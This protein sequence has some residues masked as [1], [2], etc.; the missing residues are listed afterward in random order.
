MLRETRALKVLL[1]EM[2]GAI[3]TAPDFAKGEIGS[4]CIA[5]PLDF[6]LPC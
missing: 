4:C 6:S 3:E 2:S 5:D 1:V